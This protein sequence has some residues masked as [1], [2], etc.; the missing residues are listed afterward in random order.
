MT[1]LRA[2]LE[3]LATE[4]SEGGEYSRWVA[5]RIRA[6]LVAH[7]PAPAEGTGLREALT[8]QRA[9]YLENKHA[10]YSGSQIVALIDAML[11]HRDA[12]TTPAADGGLVHEAWAAPCDEH[13]VKWC[14]ENECKIA[15][16]DKIVHRSRAL[17]QKH[18][19]EANERA[20]LRGKEGS[21]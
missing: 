18:A 14:E 20:A 3:A 1:T 21:A 13:G 7:P 8:G 11:A 12:L 9:I 17:A 15:T 2:A 5:P 16:F 10:L 19:D 6:I 4:V